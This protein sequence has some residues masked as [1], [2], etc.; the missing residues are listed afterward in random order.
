MIGSVTPAEQKTAPAATGFKSPAKGLLFSL[1]VPGSGEIYAKSWIKGLVFVG[2]ETGAWVIYAVHQHKGNDLERDYTAYADKYWSAAVWT[3]W[4]ESLSEE[5]QQVYSHHEL[6]ET[7]TQQYY[8]MIGKYQKYNA[9]WDDVRWVPGVVTTDTSKKSLYYMAL[10]GR[11]NDELK[12]ATTATALVL[13]NHVL[14]A[15][16]AVW[17]IKRYNKTVKPSIKVNYVWI[18][19]RP[20]LVANLTLNW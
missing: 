17:T 1:T 7:K 19:N 13:A 3:Q 4:W 5:D 2:I 14:S 18:N 15:L 9:G 6:P 20:Q 8:E 16:D 11:S 10:R 12:L